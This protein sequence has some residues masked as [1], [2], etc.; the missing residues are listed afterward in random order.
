M[1]KGTQRYQVGEKK[2]RICRR[3]TRTV[4]PLLQFPF[5]LLAPRLMFCALSSLMR[6]Q[7][8]RRR[9]WREYNNNSSDSFTHPF[10]TVF[11][12]LLEVVFDSYVCR[13]ERKRRRSFAESNARVPLSPPSRF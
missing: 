10:I 8:G 4:P 13:G 7:R 5:F 3:S 9:L 11:A 6:E 1:R 2:K 12:L